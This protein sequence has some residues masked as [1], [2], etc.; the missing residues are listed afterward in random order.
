VSVWHAVA[1][2]VCVRRAWFFWVVQLDFTSH[3]LTMIGLYV[4]H[5]TRCT[6]ARNLQPRG[7]GWGVHRHHARAT[8]PRD[9]RGCPSWGYVTAHAERGR[10]NAV[11]FVRW[12]ISTCPL[13]RPVRPIVDAGIGGMMRWCSASPM[14]P[15]AG[16]QAG[17][18]PRFQPRF[19]W[20]NLCHKAGHSLP[21]SSSNGRFALRISLEMRNADV[22]FL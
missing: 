10:S 4:G 11:F 21:G 18:N 14:R 20:G 16:C 1:V 15:G 19:R 17:A 8:P 2:A 3:D 13:A 5:R 22:P 6:G 7:N 9:G 12:M